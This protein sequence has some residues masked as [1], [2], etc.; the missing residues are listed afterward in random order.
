MT[1][2][3]MTIEEEIKQ[4]TFKDEHSKVLVNIIFTSGWINQKMNCYLKKYDLSPQQFNILR[5][6]RGQYPKCATLGLI[7]DRMLDKMSNASRLVEKLR[8]KEFVTRSIDDI[9]RRQ[10]KIAITEK[11][12]KILRQTDLEDEQQKQFA[13]IL[14][15]DEAK[16]LNELLNKLRN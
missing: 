2:N 13:K 1:K 11:G 16:M 3:V 9:D 5:I 12:M 10:V 6:L 4:D 15:D 8:I 7:Q 14:S